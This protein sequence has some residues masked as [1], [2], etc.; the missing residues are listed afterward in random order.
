MYDETEVK[1]YSSWKRKHIL[2]YGGVV[3]AIFL[4]ITGVA[5]GAWSVNQINNNLITSIEI[6][7]DS[8]KR[9]EIPE[10]T[11]EYER[12][13]SAGGLFFQKYGSQVKVHTSQIGLG[14]KKVAPNG[15]LTAN[16]GTIGII[17]APNSGMTI[18]STPVAR[19][20]DGRATT[21][22]SGTSYTIKTTAVQKLAVAAKKKGV[23]NTGLIIGGDNLETT[24]ENTGVIT[25]TPETGLINTGDDQ[26]PVL[27]VENPF[28]F[29]TVTISH[30]DLASGGSKT[31]YTASS[32]TATYRIISLA[33]VATGGTNFSGGDRII[34]IGTS[35]VQKWFISAS[36]AATTGS[37]SLVMSASNSGIQPS[38]TS[39]AITDTAAGANIVAKYSGGTTDYTA[40][41]VVLSIIMIQTAY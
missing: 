13:L 26:N 16:T 40:G 27:S 4:G 5:L 33:S 9:A 24:I 7:E 21:T 36:A 14:I 6:I 28:I 29:A 23:V 39:D 18:T 20:V 12:T 41:A 25:F 1:D 17:P 34:N 38:T 35:S 19:D 31:L 22:I 3:L 11:E 10:W 15:Y 30:T 8:A 32:G 37:V 2:L